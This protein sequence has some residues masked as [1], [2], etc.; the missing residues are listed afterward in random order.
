MKKST[1]KKHAVPSLS[2]WCG[3]LRVSK[4][5]LHNNKRV[6]HTTTL[7]PIWLYIPIYLLDAIDKH[8]PPTS[9]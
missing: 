9:F 7:L 4:I 3:L 8:T 6:I 1:A 5:N 2:F